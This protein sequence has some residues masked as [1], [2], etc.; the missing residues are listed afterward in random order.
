MNKITRGQRL[1]EWREIG[2][3]PVTPMAVR[4]LE[5]QRRPKLSVTEQKE[6]EKLLRMKR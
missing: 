4:L 6:M 1:K 3:P 2:K 5:L